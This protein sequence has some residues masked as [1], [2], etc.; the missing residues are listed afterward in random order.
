MCIRRDDANKRFV[1]SLAC[2]LAC[3]L[4]YFDC[5]YYTIVCGFC[6]KTVQREISKKC[7]SILEVEVNCNSVSDFVFFAS[8]KI[9]RK[10][11]TNVNISW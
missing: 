11:L 10:N 7:A 1:L 2:L 3:L 5:L 8:N 4:C 6:F 9:L